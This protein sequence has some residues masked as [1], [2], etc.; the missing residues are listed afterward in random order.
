MMTATI[1]PYIPKIPA[2]TTGIKDFITTLGLQIAILLMP[3]PA[4][5]VP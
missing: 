2:M 1:I 4:L 5:A 3:V